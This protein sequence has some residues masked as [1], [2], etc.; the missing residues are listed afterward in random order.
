MARF[1]SQSVRIGLIVLG[2]L[3]VVIGSLIAYSYSSTTSAVYEAQIDSMHELESALTE[4]LTDFIDNGLATINIISY[5]TQMSRIASGMETG[6]NEILAP[7]LDQLEIAEAIFIYDKD[8]DVRAAAISDDSELGDVNVKDR[9]YFAATMN[10]E[11]YMADNV[12]QSRFTGVYS[13]VM[14]APIVDFMG[15]PRGGVAITLDFGKFAAKYIN[16]V[17]IGERGYPY[18]LDKQGRIIAHPDESLM[19]KDLS[20][21][22]FIRSSLDSPE[23]TMEYEWQGEDKVQLWRHLPRTGWVFVASAY[24]SDLT[25]AATSQATVQLGI[26]AAAIVLL[27]VALMLA[28]GRMIIQPVNAIRDYAAKV[29]QGDLSA[30]LKGNFKYELGELADNIRAMVEELK[31]KLGFAQGVLGGVSEALPSLVANEKGEITFV[32]GLLLHTIGKPG[33]PEDYLGENIDTFFF[34]DGR[35]TR[36]SEALNTGQRQQGEMVTTDAEGVERTL[37]VKANP[38]VD[39]DGNP[40]GVFTF[41]HDLTQIRGQQREIEVKNETIRKAADRAAHIAE[42]VAAAADRLSGKVDEVS[43]GAGIQSQRTA[44]TAVSMEEMNATVLE[45]ARNASEAAQS[46]EQATTIAG[47]GEEVVRGVVD[48]I[49]GVSERIG[50]LKANMDG[51]GDRAEAIGQVITVIED[52]ADQTNLL[53]LNAAIE[54]ARAGEAGRGFAVVADEVRKLAEKTMGATKQV[55]EAITAIQQGA[56]ASI[57]ATEL[58]DESVRK[59][60][61][62]AGDSG[63][64]LARIVGVVSEAAQQVQSIAAA[65]EQQSSTSEEINRA[66]E[67]INRITTETAEGTGESS[68]AVAELVR[69]AEELQEIIGELRAQ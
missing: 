48:A 64:V 39:L 13:I 38:I 26:G 35:P 24:K 43:Q 57:Q 16:D 11:S 37:E 9:D 20:D 58:A 2:L 47:E 41:Y 34:A 45:V 51:L 66:I 59:T 52:I 36:T 29:G 44:E 31:E 68:E 25:R 67:D 62:L 23:G 49:H 18:I 8:G 69:Q 17:R 56:S 22:A 4:T 10:G 19:L 21:F 32:N 40:A 1:Q 30:S 7:Y 6:G 50:E 14:A 3:V 33:T 55:G 65:S 42:E 27:G 15:K 12:I 61:G 28:V 53:A 54:A 63:E 5:D 46:A 60:T